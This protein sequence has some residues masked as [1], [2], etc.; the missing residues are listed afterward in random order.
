MAGRVAHRAND[1][2]LAED[3]PGTW[4]VDAH[5]HIHPA[6]DRRR[7]LDAAAAN[8]AEAARRLGLTGPVTGVLMLTESAGVHAFDELGGAGGEPVPGWTVSRTAE[9]VSLRLTRPGGDRVYIVAGRQIVTSDRLEVLALASRADVPDGL[10]LEAA[11]GRVKAAGAVP[12]IPWGFGKWTG[13]RRRRL[14]EFLHSPAGDGV[15]LG[16]NGGRLAFGPLPALLREA[17]KRGLPVVPGSDPLPFASQAERAGRYGFVLTAE[18]DDDHPART[19]VQYLL[20]RK[21]QPC[22]FGRLT[23]LPAFLISQLRMQWRG[24]SRRQ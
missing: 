5:V 4:L 2:T 19:V 10:P 17:R 15:F 22:P 24:R 9:P 16:D 13:S 1:C 6:F 12:V 18:I 21:D 7:F 23:P 11:V 8:F 14:A 3:G 20:S